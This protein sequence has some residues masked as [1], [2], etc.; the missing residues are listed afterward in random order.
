ME[1]V[2]E[3][4]YFRKN[5]WGEGILLYPGQPAG[6]KGFVLSIRLKLYREAAKDYEYMAMASKLGKSADV[7]M[8]VRKLVTDFQIWN[9]EISGYEQACEQL[10]SL[11]L[12]QHF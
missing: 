9:R 12:Y 4:P 11:I 7:D 8:I 10:A 2:W 5:F 6:F 3:A 1:G